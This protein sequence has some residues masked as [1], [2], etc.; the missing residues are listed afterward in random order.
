MQ[1]YP[2]YLQIGTNQYC[3]DVAG[4]GLLKT[5]YCPTQQHQTFANS[6]LPGRLMSKTFQGSSAFLKMPRV[7]VLPS[8]P[9]S[10]NLN[11]NLKYPDYESLAQKVL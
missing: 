11:T 1:Y 9:K 2:R 8:Q 7:T 4:A 3:T 6:P 10:P 5:S